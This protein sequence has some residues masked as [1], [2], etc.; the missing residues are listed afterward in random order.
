MKKVKLFEEF[1]ANHIECDNC[2][3]TW[4][5]QDGGDDLYICHECGHDNEPVLGES[6]D[7]AMVYG[8]IDLLLKVDDIENRK[9]M[10]LSAIADFDAEGIKYN[11]QEFLDKSGV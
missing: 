1:T 7:D 2:G 3:W 4:M 11:K 9:E 8:I 6:K 5:L 10:A